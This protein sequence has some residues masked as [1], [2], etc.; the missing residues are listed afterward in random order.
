[1][2][3]FSLSTRTLTLKGISNTQSAFDSPFDKVVVALHGWQDN[4]ASFAPLMEQFG[5]DFPI[6]ALDWPGHGESEWRSAD[7][8]YYFIDY[9]DDLQQVLAQ[10]QATE[11]H[12]V[13]HS[14]GAMVASLYV[15]CFADRIA[16]LTLIEGVGLVC[17]SANESKELLKRALVQRM[18]AAKCRVYDSPQDVI[19]RRLAVSD[20][21]ECIAAPLMARNIK[22][23]EDGVSLRTDPRIKH[24]S[25]FRYSLEQ[26]HAL[27]AD[28]TVP[29]LLIKG[30]EG[31]QLVR[32]NEEKFSKYYKTLNVEMLEGGHHCHMENP[33]LC[34]RLIGAHL[35]QNGA[36]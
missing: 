5:N 23:V 9:V 3:T 24:Y 27:L 8:H 16:S 32:D 17:A 31:Y 12:L 26:A 20:F 2:E 7:A 11:I 25:A 21:D 13:G 22:S 30:T 36:I 29:T 14:M 1:M 19:N 15:A 34:A 4:A 6:F 18:R 33:K 35:H 10:C 28:I